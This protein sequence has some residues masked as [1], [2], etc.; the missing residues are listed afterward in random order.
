[1][2]DAEKFCTKTFGNSKSTDDV[3]VRIVEEFLLEKENQ[4]YLNAAYA[5]NKAWPNVVNK[6]ADNF[7]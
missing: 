1:M 2:G 6:V 7:L 5:V 3:E 4:K